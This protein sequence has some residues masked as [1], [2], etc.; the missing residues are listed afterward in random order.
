MTRMWPLRAHPE[1]RIGS[2]LKPDI[3]ADFT[4]ALWIVEAEDKT[5]V[6]QLIK[7][8]P[9][10]FPDYRSYQIYTWGKL[11]EDQTAVL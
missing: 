3:D 11:L 1:L 5:S 7:A 10:Y 2:G 6:E 9:F 4:G 8:D